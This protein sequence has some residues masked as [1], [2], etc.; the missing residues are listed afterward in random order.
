[1]V[2]TAMLERQIEDMRQQL[3]LASDRAVPL[4]P[5]ITSGSH[6]KIE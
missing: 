3:L 4:P 2:E 6:G 1:M 5:L